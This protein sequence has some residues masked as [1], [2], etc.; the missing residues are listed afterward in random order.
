[1]K[2]PA[3][4]TIMI[5]A[6]LAGTAAQAATVNDRMTV[7]GFAYA[8][9]NDIDTARE[10]VDALTAKAMK[11]ARKRAQIAGCAEGRRIGDVRAGTDRR[12]T[13]KGQARGTGRADDAHIHRHCRGK[14]HLRPRDEVGRMPTR[15]LTTRRQRQPR[16]T[17]G[18]QR[19]SDEGTERVR[20]GG[21]GSERHGRDSAHARRDPGGGAA[22][23]RRD[24]VRDPR[25]EHHGA[26]HAAGLDENAQGRESGSMGEK[27]DHRDAFATTTSGSRRGSRT[28]TRSSGAHR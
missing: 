19:N 21:S 23:D 3:T 2:M 27:R 10:T 28:C 1:M 6:A 12:E 15:G 14:G 16:S 24:G 11:H 7:T 18:K 26:E 9:I 20:V 4:A 5:L 8:T 13:L 22:D 17:T 25:V